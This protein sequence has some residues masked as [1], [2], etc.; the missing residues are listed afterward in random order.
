[1]AHVPVLLKEAIY[2]LDPK[3][4]DT[5]L[6]ATINGGGHA[7]VI[8]QKIGE[9]GTLVGID[10]DKKILENLKS[11]I[12][13]TKSETNLILINGNFRDLDELLKNKNIKTINGAIFDLGMS[14][15]QLE[16]SGRGFSFQK[17]EPLLMTYKSEIGPNDL[18]ARDILN[19]WNEKEIADVLYKY[20]EERYSRRIARKITE[21]RREKPIKTTFDLVELIRLSVPSAYRNNRRIHC[22]TRTFQALRIAVNDE[23]N[24]LPEGIKK[25]WKLLSIG[26]RLAVISFHSLEDRIVKNF[27]REMA[28]DGQGKILTKKP[29]VPT[30]EEQKL[31][32]RSRS[33][34]LRVM[35]KI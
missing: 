11:E 15:I 34:K 5:I 31:N 23:L 22:A 8:M 20:G 25:A 18:T 4:G 7:R 24:A 17:D 27:F 12:R 35:E 16:E 2:Y 26:S 14:S 9:A 6:D 33:A 21:I 1:M 10:Q 13:S 29:I 28:Q 19:K 32:P 30:N 3:P